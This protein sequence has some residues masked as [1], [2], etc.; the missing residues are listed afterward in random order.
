MA[1]KILIFIPTYMEREN[2]GRISEKILLLN[3]DADILF[4]DD[5][6]PDGTGQILDEIAA[7]HENIQ[8]LHREGKLG[9]GSAHA[10]GINYA[11]DKGY[12]IL[13]TM[14]CDFTHSP[15]DIPKLL[16]AAEGHDVSVGSRYLAE[17]SLPG[18]K[19]TRR[20]LTHFAHFLTVTLLG[21]KYDATGAFRVYNLKSVPRDFIKL[22]ESRSYAFFFESLFVLYNNRMA[23]NEIPIVLP[24]RTYGHSKMSLREAFKSARFL[25]GLALR[26][27]AEP[28][29]LQL[30]RKTPVIDQGLSDPQGWDSYWDRNGSSSHRAYSIIA[31]VYRKAFI[32]RNLERNIRES[33]TRDSMLLHAGC[34]SGQADTGLH[35]DYR[36]TAADICPKALEMYCKNNLDVAD[37]RHGSIFSLPFPDAT[38][39]GVYNLGVMEHFTHGEI[40]AILKEFNRVLNDKGKILIFWPHKR[41]TSVMVLRMVH[42]VLNNMLKKNIRLHPDEISLIRGRDEAKAILEKSGFSMAKYKFG[43]SDIFIQS[44]IVGKK[45]QTPPRINDSGGQP[46]QQG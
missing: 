38:F 10:M 44:V 18:W 25:A 17:G 30:A 11:Y 37:V 45:N 32:K 27:F 14:D 41:G 23:I 28:E 26:K 36:V 22:V 7:R 39:D 34:G 40:V 46:Q 4:V 24:A 5:N 43:P 6:S 33:F 1:N 15:E 29:S 35:E 16:E 3:L 31:A 20:F 2:V 9:I 21:M 42:F 13:V 8:V 19:Q 12:D